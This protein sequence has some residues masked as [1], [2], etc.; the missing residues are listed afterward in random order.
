MKQAYV[1]DVDESV[2]HMDENRETNKHYF[3]DVF[4]VRKEGKAGII[5]GT[6]LQ[7]RIFEKVYQME[8]ALKKFEALK[9]SGLKW[10][11]ME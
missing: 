6:G 7:V 11:F 10:V 2:L 1:M 9:T 4:N 8:K 5:A 3:W